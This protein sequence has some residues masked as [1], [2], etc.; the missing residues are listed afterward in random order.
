MFMSPHNLT[1]LLSSALPFPA[2]HKFNRSLTG[3]QFAARAS[4]LNG[5]AIKLHRLAI[6]RSRRAEVRDY[7]RQ[8]AEAHIWTA[9]A[10]LTSVQSTHLHVELYQQPDDNHQKRL[11]GLQLVPSPDFDYDYIEAQ[12]RLYMEL[13]VLSEQYIEIGADKTLAFF[14]ANTLSYLSH[15]L[16][17][18]APVNEAS[19][20]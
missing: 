15:H 1:A 9:E 4:M 11:D 14:A 18:F 12:N 17:Q 19:C 13:I 3:A 10:L 5:C 16:Q 7:A 20:Q 8:M 6:E 2:T